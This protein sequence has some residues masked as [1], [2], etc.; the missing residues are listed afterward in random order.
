M[1]TFEEYNRVQTLLG[2]K[3][4]PRPIIHEFTFAGSINGTVYGR[5]Y[6]AKTKKKLLISGEIREHAHYHCTRKSKKCNQKKNLP[7]EKLETML[8]KEI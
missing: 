7:L 1:I 3:D 4:K 6:T 8:E 5:F 2:K